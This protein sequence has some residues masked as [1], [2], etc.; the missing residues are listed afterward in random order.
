M[1]VCGA[2]C[3]ISCSVKKGQKGIRILAPL[4]GTKRKKDS[5]IHK[6]I[7]KQNQPVLVG[8]RAVYVFDVLFRDLWPRFCALDVA[9][10]LRA[11]DG[12]SHIM[13][14]FNCPVQRLLP[15]VTSL[16]AQTCK[17]QGLSGIGRVD[18]RHEHADTGGFLFEGSLACP[19]ADSVQPARLREA[20]EYP[21]IALKLSGREDKNSF[22]QEQS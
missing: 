1:C 8:F 20:L 4:I 6:D 3:R 14:Q 2:R 17:R 10:H 13:A 18:D 21:E 22:H 11:L 19:T 9:M 12:S 5:E 15:M 7:S 16:W